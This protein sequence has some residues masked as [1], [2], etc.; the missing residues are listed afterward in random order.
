MLAEMQRCRVCR[1]A[2]HGVVQDE[3]L[4]HVKLLW[5]NWANL[6]ARPIDD[7]WRAVAQHHTGLVERINCMY[8]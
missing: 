7:H 3:D 2:V 4:I 6:P 5:P 1:A 8:A